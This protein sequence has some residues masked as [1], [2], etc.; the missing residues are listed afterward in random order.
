MY[1]CNCIWPCGA[2]CFTNKH[3]FKVYDYV[4]IPCFKLKY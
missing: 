4:P 3:L 1:L 2:D